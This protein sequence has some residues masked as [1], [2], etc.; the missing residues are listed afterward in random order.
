MGVEMHII[1]GVLYVGICVFG[2][3]GNG[4][5]LI[6][7]IRQKPYNW[8]PSTCYLFNLVVA[9]AL[10]LMF[11][12]LWACYS[13]NQMVWNFGSFMCKLTGAVTK[14]N[15]FASVFFLTAMSIDRWMAVVR[16]TKP[17]RFRKQ[18][19]SQIICLAIWFV[20]LVF[21]IPD[22][23][24]RNL[25]PKLNFYHR[26]N[27]TSDR[28]NSLVVIEEAA[29]AVTPILSIPLSTQRE[30]MSCVFSVP[31]NFSAIMSNE[32][33][34]G[35][36]DFF[37]TL[38]GYILPLITICACYISI[39]LTVRRKVQGVKKQSRVAKLATFIITAFFICWTPYHFLNLYSAFFGWWKLGPADPTIFHTFMPYFIF[40]GYANSAINPILYSF[41][42]TKFQES[43]KYFCCG[44]KDNCKQEDIKQLTKQERMGATQHTNL[45]SSKKSNSSSN[46]QQPR[47]I[48]SDKVE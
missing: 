15:M 45:S 38:I 28:N 2:L 36:L 5:V 10:F 25:R 43:A 23:I 29:S 26:V 13:L 44:K 16:A 22:V 9:D 4:L 8:S 32:V 6:V 27:I 33:F 35:L 37:R 31:Q 19:V 46:E 42:S 14:L 48:E 11:L 18:A 1:Q 41:T 7:L 30:Q 47:D 21:S 39:V 24:Y 3:I 17:N 40:L 34:M 20:S 12:P